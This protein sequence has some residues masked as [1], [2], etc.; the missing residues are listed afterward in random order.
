V[1]IV[2]DAQPDPARYSAAFRYVLR[3]AMV[4]IRIL[5]VLL[6]LVVLGVIALDAST[7][8]P[9]EALAVPLLVLGVGLALVLPLRSRQVS[10]R[11]VPEAFR[12]P[13]RI[14][15]SEQSVRISSPLFHTEYAWGAFV[16]TVELPGQVLLMLSPRQFV[17]VPTDRLD[18]AQRQELH[19]FLANRQFVR[20]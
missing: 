1:H 19:Q 10:L 5:G 13:S 12:Q 17:S 6:T 2:I 7:G 14:E 8:K 3:R 16:R 20:V 15:L 9:F 4:R 18:P 11:A